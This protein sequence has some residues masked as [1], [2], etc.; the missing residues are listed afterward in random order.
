M[1]RLAVERAARVIAVSRYA[2]GAA[3]RFGHADPARID[4]VYLGVD[5]ARY[6][7][8]RDREV[9]E[10]A[11]SELGVSGRYLLWVGTIEPRKDLPTLLEAFASLA[12]AGM[13]HRLVVAGQPGWGMGDFELALDR[14]GTRDRVVRTGYVSEEQKLA[15]YRGA[16]ALAY[17]SIAEGFGIQ[18]VEAMATGCPVVTTTGSAPQ[19]VGGDAVVLVPPRDATQLASALERILTDPAERA[20]LRERGLSRARSFDWSRTADGTLGSY[21]RALGVR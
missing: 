12:A 3:E 11:R 17:P 13:D 21:R 19:E 15:L 1:S 20:T 7:P 4:V 2:R 18:V 9:D 10:L 5:L 16:E 14:T 8:G 6:T